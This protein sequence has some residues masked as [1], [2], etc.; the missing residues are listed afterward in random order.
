MSLFSDL[1][2]RGLST[3]YTRY[4][5]EMERVL[6]DT[7]RRGMPVS[8]PQHQSVAAQLDTQ[9]AASLEQ[10]QRLVPDEAKE[11]TKWKRK[12]NVRKLFKP[13]NQALRRYMRF[14]GHPIPLHFKTGKETTSKDELRR[15]ARSTGDPLYA[16]VDAYR[17][18]KT[19]RTN[20]IKN[21]T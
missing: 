1:Q 4:V 3:S 17:D 14:R 15:L 16:A 13:S 2:Q 7:S 8:L 5:V 18:A 21:W 20:H 12:P 6:A 9:A 10:I 19:V 11:L